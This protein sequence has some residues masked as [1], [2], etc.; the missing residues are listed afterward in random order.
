[1]N[2]EYKLALRMLNKLVKKEE[3]VTERGENE[4]MIGA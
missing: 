4:E 3:E 2:F 1:M